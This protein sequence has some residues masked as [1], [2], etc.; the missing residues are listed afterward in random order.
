M[1]SRD[2]WIGSVKNVSLPIGDMDS[3]SL[4]GFLLGKYTL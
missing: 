3:H 4:E 1:H 2:I